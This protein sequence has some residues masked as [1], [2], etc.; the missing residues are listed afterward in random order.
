MENLLYLAIFD[1]FSI[2]LEVFAPIL[3]YFDPKMAEKTQNITQG[4]V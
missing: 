3:S 2:F 1:R 4:S